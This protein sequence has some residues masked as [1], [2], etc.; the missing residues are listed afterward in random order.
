MSE[1]GFKARLP[2]LFTSLRW[3][4]TVSPSSQPGAVS[5]LD[6]VS[7]RDVLITQHLP[8]PLPLV[9]VVMGLVRM[10]GYPYL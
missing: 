7:S 6:A 1:L 4:T 2:V 5:S 8:L 9:V 10:T 3:R